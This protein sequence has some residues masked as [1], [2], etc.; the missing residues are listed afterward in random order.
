MTTACK[1]ER[2]CATEDL[3]DGEL[4]GVFV[5]R[6]PVVLLRLPDGLRAYLDRCPHLGARLSEGRLS[7]VSLQCRVHHWQYDVRSGAG[8]NPKR[9]CLTR[10]PV[11]ERQGAVYVDVSE[12][13]DG[14]P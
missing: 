7:G 2:V 4:L 8:I 12:V 6:V 11:F 14:R 13:A 1:A 5:R 3:W 10:L 9:A